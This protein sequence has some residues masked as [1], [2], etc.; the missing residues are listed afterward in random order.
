MK[1]V[2]GE[3]GCRCLRLGR[4]ASVLCMAILSARCPLNVKGLRSKGN[5]LPF[6]NILHISISK[7]SVH[8]LQP[9]LPQITILGLLLHPLLNQFDNLSIIKLFRCLIAFQHQF[10]M[11]SNFILG[12]AH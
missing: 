11:L 10:L 5:D 9:S 6:R 1:H 12:H 4:R 7:T 3:P 8:T 2:T